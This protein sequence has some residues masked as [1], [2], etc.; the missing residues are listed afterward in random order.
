MNTYNGL[1]YKTRGNANPKGRPRVYFCCHEADFGGLFSEISDEI[2]SFQNNAAIW[3]YDP[4]EGIPDDEQFYLDLAQ[5]QL[6][7]VPVTSNFIYQ[8]NRAR[9]AEF[10]FALDHH[11]PVLPLMQENGIKQDFNRICGTLQYLN[12]F[13]T[14]TDSSAI[15][16]EEKLTLFLH[17][18]LVSDE[19][20]ERVRNAFDAYIFLSYRKKDRVYAREVMRLIH[21]IEFCRDIAIWYDEFLTP[22]EN[23]NEEIIEAMKKSSLFALVVTP[24]LLEDSNYVMRKEYPHARAENKPILPIEAVKTDGEALSRR[25]DGLTAGVPVQ[26]VAAISEKLSGFLQAASLREND[27]DPVH[28]FLIGLAYLSGID[29]EVD[30]ERALSLITSAAE[31]GLADAYR[32][33]VSMYH[34]GEGTARDYQASIHWQKRY[35]AYLKKTYPDSNIGEVLLEFYVA[36]SAL[37]DFLK[38]E[39]DIKAAKEAFLTSLDIAGKLQR[40]DGMAYRRC[41]GISYW[42]LSRV[43]VL[44]GKLIDARKWCQRYLK[45]S[46]ALAKEMETKETRRDLSLSYYYMG[47]IFK[48]EGKLTE[49]GQWCQKG[50]VITESL[51]EETGTAESRRDLSVGCDDM[52]RICKAEGKYREAR[53]WFRKSLEI[54]EK[55]LQETGS[56]S[57][58]RDLSLSYYHLGRISRAEGKLAEAREWCMKDLKISEELSKKLG[59]VQSRRDLSLSYYSLGRI[60]EEEGNFAVARECF[61]QGYRISEGLAEETGMVQSRR[62]LYV[63]CDDLSRISETEGKLSEAKEWSLKGLE[64]TRLLVK[65][66]GTVEARRDLSVSY[67]DLGRLAEAGGDPEE[68]R[69][70]FLEC[71]KIRQALIKED[72]SIQS[73]EDMAGVYYQ[74]GTLPTVSVK[75]RLSYLRKMLQIAKKMFDTTGDRK[76]SIIAEAAEE[77]IRE[78]QSGGNDIPEE[79]NLLT[80]ILSWI[81]KE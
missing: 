10:Q 73:R 23:Y 77:K 44:E 6:F 22:G 24:S 41:L 46:E 68:A 3:Y 74:L 36:Y 78:L 17:T 75:E 60:N 4:A 29:V 40:I 49:A 42:N 35:I 21:S 33:L 45:I 65:E 7:V 15:S 79:P 57:A 50:L 55:L 43:S 70:Y 28:N 54:R 47:R 64:I 30:H 38:S 48:A 34:N 66:T 19:L 72:D 27:S 25:F 32:K 8:D 53:E 52:G 81:R 67:A 37:G 11:I 12:R 9:T 69:E 61:L 18:V 14:E 63:G 59:A 16:Y 80:R 71:L 76:Y 26:D 5:M 31:A 20:A 2:L 1:Q 13:E 56:V 39:G 58:Q 51:A 62:D